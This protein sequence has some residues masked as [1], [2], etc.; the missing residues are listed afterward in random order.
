MRNSAAPT[1]WFP[2]T[3]RPANLQILLGHVKPIRTFL[4][5]LQPLAAFAAE[6][7]AGQQQTRRSGRAAPDTP[8]KLMELRKAESLG[9]FDQH[10]RGVGNVDAD[11]NDGRR[12]QNPVSPLPQ[13][14][15]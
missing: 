5:D 13:T 2:A 7:L 6:F 9:I 10:D 12:H 11:L 4:H 14:P 8:A 1:V 3:P 15:S